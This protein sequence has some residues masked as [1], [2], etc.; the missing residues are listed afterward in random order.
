[1]INS[2]SLNMPDDW[3]A[4]AWC[5]VAMGLSL[6]LIYLAGQFRRNARRPAPVER[7]QR[8]PALS[9]LHVAPRFRLPTPPGLPI[10]GTLPRF[11]LQPLAQP[12]LGIRRRFDI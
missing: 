9:G 1:M 8:P 11:R 12:R 2:S 7:R 6:L 5:A 3:L 4:L 10:A